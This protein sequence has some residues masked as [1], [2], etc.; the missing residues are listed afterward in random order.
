MRPLYALLLA[1][2]LAAAGEPEPV[3]DAAAIVQP[4]LL[5]GPNYSVAPQAQV[6]GFM[7]RF[8]VTTPFGPLVAT[9]VEML[10]VRAAELPAIEALE[11]AAKTEAFA[12]ALADRAKKTGSAVWQVVANP[13]DT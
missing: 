4:S 3:L 13:I 8:D 11:R 12:H 7:A 10:A 9:S 6:H 5:S 2:T 1:T